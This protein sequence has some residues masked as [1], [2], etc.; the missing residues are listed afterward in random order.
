MMTPEY[1]PCRPE[2]RA[3]PYPHF[4]ELRDEAPVYW[5]PETGAFCVSRYDDV[6]YV[7]RSPE[8]FS[9]RAMFTFLMN[10]GREGRPPFSWAMLHFIVSFMLKTRLNPG[11]FATARNL[12]ASDGDDH[13]AMRGIVNRGFTP[14]RIA[15]WEDRVRQLVDESMAILRTGEPFDLVRDLAIPLPVT[16]IAEMLGVEASRL[17]D[18]KRWSD[19]IVETSTGPSR[20]D[21]FNPRMRETI[22]EL[23]RYVRKVA[24]ERRRNPSDDL[25]SI[26]VAEQD[27]DQA[28]T[29]REVIQFVML[30][31]VAGNETTTNL[32]GNCV[33]ALLDHPEELA[34]VAADPSLVPGALEETLRYDAPVQLVFRTA[35]R[36]LELAGTK[37]PEGSFVV[38]LLGSA[39]RDERRFPEP[40]RFDVTRNPQGHVGFGFGKHFCLGASLARLE[41]RLAIEALA[42]QLPRLERG[43]Q[44]PGELVD[45]FLVRGPRR[46]ELRPAV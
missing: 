11:D 27:G 14:R 42:P 43:S 10:Q 22:I 34:K 15:A 30:L 18:F 39:N 13:S 37:I 5:A 33:K 28:L 21:P 24:E 40:D 6:M 45:S 38:P 20:G 25:V 3:N 12:I 35:T 31:L 16:I 2:W 46:L 44:G 36:D 7:L 17:Q 4:R 1:D 8:L 23:A 41:A 9:S 26:I 32:I 29:I 19:A